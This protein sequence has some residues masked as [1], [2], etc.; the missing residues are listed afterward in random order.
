MIEVDV[1][2]QGKATYAGV[3][4]R[5]VN[6]QD[7]LY[8]DA[9]ADFPCIRKASWKQGMKEARTFVDSLKPGA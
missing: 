3:K 4:M 9:L 7:G 8:F 5:K 2:K 1:S 6:I